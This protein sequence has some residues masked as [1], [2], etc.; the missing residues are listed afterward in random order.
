MALLNYK[1]GKTETYAPDMTFGDHTALDWGALHLEGYATP[2][3]SRGS[4]CYRIGPAAFFSGDSLV[5]GNAVVT[6]LRGGD[7]AV[8]MDFRA[9]TLLHISTT[10]DQPQEK[11]DAAC[12]LAARLYGASLPARQQAILVGPTEVLIVQRTDEGDDTAIAFFLS[13][14]VKLES[15]R[16]LVRSLCNASVLSP[17]NGFDL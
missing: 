17:D 16:A 5:P 4:A 14:E 6:R 10:I 9:G 1:K 8:L 2:G 11:L 12:A 13:P 15:A 7:A 3:H